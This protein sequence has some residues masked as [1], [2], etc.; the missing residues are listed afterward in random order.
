MG[1]KM[2]TKTTKFLDDLHDR[3][4][5]VRKWKHGAVSTGVLALDQA[6][7]KGGMP[8]G[9]LID[10]YGDE[11]LGKT[12]L[13]LAMMAERVR[14]GER[15]I[16]VDVEHRLQ[17]D[18][19]LQ[20]IP[21]T[22]VNEDGQVR[23][24]DDL[25]RV[26]QPMLGEETFSLIEKLIREPS[27]RMVALDSV[28]AL[29]FAEE[30]VEDKFTTPIGIVARR[31]GLFTKRILGTVYEFGP[32]VVFIN[33][34]RMS[35]NTYGPLLKTST[36]GKAIR[37]ACSLRIHIHPQELIKQGDTIIGQK[38]RLRIEKNT[39]GA[40]QRE[41]SLS[42]MFGKGIDRARDLVDTA[43][44]S[45][46]ATQSG[47]WYKMPWK[48]QELSGHGEAEFA[49]KVAPHLDELRTYVQEQIAAK[50]KQLEADIEA[51]AKARMAEIKA[52]KAK[53]KVVAKDPKDPEE[54]T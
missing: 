43:L 19:A 50:A 4:D 1:E 52:P 12:T 13:V 22:Y 29:T 5:I 16:Y 10:L 46:V 37:F 32:L 28:P 33:Q 35:P 42:I 26:Y 48:G 30:V 20:I 15:C 40:P 53:A 44:E 2:D 39:I 7:T 51:A 54:P 8:R 11:G 27:I 45:G 25:F 23:Q 17:N 38:V 49:A 31:I 6:T 14:H 36:G 24:E 9:L 34:M 47:G 41:T 21:G 3:F 18:L